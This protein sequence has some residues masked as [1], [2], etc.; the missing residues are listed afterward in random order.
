M[1]YHRHLE[2]AVDPHEYLPLLAI[3]RDIREFPATPERGTL[4][5]DSPQITDVFPIKQSRHIGVLPFKDLATWGGQ[6]YGPWPTTRAQRW[7][8]E[9]TKA[10]IY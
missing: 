1:A 3:G 8:G 4:F 6:F 10:S 2:A 9:L 5:V 7:K